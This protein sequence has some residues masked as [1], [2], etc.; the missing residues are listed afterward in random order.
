MLVF[1]FAFGLSMDYEVFLLA[2]IKELKDRGYDCRRAV[3]L[4]LQ[5]SGRII[6]S[7][8]LLMVIVFA[9]F[10]AGQMLM[11]KEMGIALAVAVAVDATLVRCLLVPAAMSLFGE[12]NWWAPAPLK[13]LY[14]RFGLR[15]HV[16]LP[17]VEAGEGA[18]GEAGVAAPVVQGARVPAPRGAVARAT[19]A[20]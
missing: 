9:G 15:E 11:V 4:G 12:F 18:P 13:R 1:A 17:P 20:G 10:A 2:R 16:E 8:A 6:T 7:A 14:R 19:T 5:R 3:Q